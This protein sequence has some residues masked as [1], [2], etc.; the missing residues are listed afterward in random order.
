MTNSTFP[1]LLDLNRAPL[2][3]NRL[4]ALSNPGLILVSGSTGSGKSTTLAAI[5]ADLQRSDYKVF[6]LRTFDAEVLPGLPEIA[7]DSFGQSMIRSVLGVHQPGV[8]I[9]DDLRTV[10]A[11]KFAVD[12]AAKDALVIVS[13]PSGSPEDAVQ[14]M[15]DSYP[16]ADGEAAVSA[17]VVM[18]I[19]Q[20]MVPAEPSE[21]D[22]DHWAALCKAENL[23]SMANP[24]RPPFAYRDDRKVETNIRTYMS[25]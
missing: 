14:R 9:I 13:L 12:L 25:A 18:S 8:V 7:R 10:E 2:I 21:Y 22:A 19:H 11:Y 4:D 24:A 3:T 17:V 6:S 15:I 1:S 5:G 23:M 16:S 20:E